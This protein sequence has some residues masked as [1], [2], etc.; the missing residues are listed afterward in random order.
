MDTG[1]LQKSKNATEPIIQYHAVYFNV[2][3]GLEQFQCAILWP[4][5]RICVPLTQ[6]IFEQRQ[7]ALPQPVLEVFTGIFVNEV[8][9]GIIVGSSSL[10]AQLQSRK[11]C[12]P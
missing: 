8:G 10:L 12:L 3:P 5:Y 7:V 6:N 4:Q 1:N 11:V 2:A 9:W